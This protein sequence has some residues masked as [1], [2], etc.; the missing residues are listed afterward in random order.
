MLM[1]GIYWLLAITAMLI[2]DIGIVK[3]HI[4]IGPVFHI[5]T[6][7]T[8]YAYGKYKQVL[9]RELK[10]YHHILQ[11]CNNNNK[12]EPDSYLLLLFR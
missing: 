8:D 3:L 1:T 12:S 2:S 10:F 4:G 6:S 5:G 7:L 9:G 11:Y